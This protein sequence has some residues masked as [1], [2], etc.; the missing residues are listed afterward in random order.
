MKACLVSP[1][2]STLLMQRQSVGWRRARGG[3]W[4]VRG[5]LGNKPLTHWWI[6]VLL[7]IIILLATRGQ[8]EREKERQ[9]RGGRDK[10][11][12][13][14]ER[15]SGRWEKE[16]ELENETR[17]PSGAL[18]WGKEKSRESWAVQS[19]QMEKL[20]DQWVG[21]RQWRRQ[22]RMESEGWGVVKKS[23]GSWACWEL[24]TIRAAAVAGDS[25]GCVCVLTRY[26]TP[27]IHL[28][29]HSLLLRAGQVIIFSVN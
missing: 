11:T 19:T 13:R 2:F 23:R 29:I 1:L 28:F 10:K 16:R 12:D 25:S 26:P 7:R 4:A 14:G 22:E 17:V 3:V 15:K 18:F 8:R 24:G 5:D 20:G 6:W 9:K 21:E 27:L